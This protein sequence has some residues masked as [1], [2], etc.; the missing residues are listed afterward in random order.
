MRY[1]MVKLFMVY[2][3]GMSLGANIEIHDVQFVAAQTI[4]DTYPLLRKHWYG[5]PKGLHLDSYKDLMGT[6]GY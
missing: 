2:L 3:G 4:E 6:D 5:T 1:D